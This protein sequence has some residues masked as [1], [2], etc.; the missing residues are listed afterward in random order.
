[1]KIELLAVYG[2]NIS[3]ASPENWARHRK[4]LATSFMNESIMRSV[5][6]ESVR[7]AGQMIDAWMDD[8]TT[9]V[10]RDMRTVS[11]NVLAAI[12]FRRSSHF[13]APEAAEYSDDPDTKFSY[14]DALQIVLDNVI[15]IM[16]IPRKHLR[17]FWLPARLRRIGKA[18]ADFGM[19]MQEMVDEE[20]EAKKDDNKGTGSLL[21]SFV[22]ALDAHHKDSSKGMSV[23]ELLGN[24]FM[25]NFAGHDT[26]TNT[27]AFAVLLLAA[28]PEVQE[29]VSEEV[30]RVIERTSQDDM[31]YNDL[32]P[33]LVR[34]RAVMV[35]SESIR[36]KF[37][38]DEH[39]DGISDSLKLSVSSLRSCRSRSTPW[40][41]RRFCSWVIERLRFLRTRTFRARS[42]LCTHIPSSGL[43]P[44][45]GSRRDG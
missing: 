39:A 7:Q 45:N 16:L 34:C 41:S 40:D 32:F 9:S 12:G 27:L 38:L 26:T 17:Y 23:D 18:A 5:W 24:L 19:Q 1:M 28:C 20:K 21:N 44:G 14:R 36:V 37:M 31:N 2:P 33:K 25:V 42:S 10:A 6:D 22:H 30:V 15:L 43:N 11:L 13:R 8:G 4:V 29:W 3:T 35:S